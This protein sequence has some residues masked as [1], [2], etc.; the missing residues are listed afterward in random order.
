MRVCPTPIEVKPQRGLTA[1]YNQT[2]QHL[3]SLMPNRCVASPL[4]LGK[5]SGTTAH[6]RAHKAIFSAG[7]ALARKSWQKS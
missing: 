5:Q 3:P 4:H 7:E 6:R 2:Q 1:A